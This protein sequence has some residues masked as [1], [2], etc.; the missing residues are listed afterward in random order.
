[1]LPKNGSPA[2]VSLQSPLCQVLAYLWNLTYNKWQE[3]CRYVNY[4]TDVRYTVDVFQLLLEARH[5]DT[6]IDN[7]YQWWDEFPLENIVTGQVFIDVLSHY[8]ADNNG[9]IEVEFYTGQSE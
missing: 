1:M 4:V 3:N 9:F 7:R 6:V 8:T 5:G 2:V